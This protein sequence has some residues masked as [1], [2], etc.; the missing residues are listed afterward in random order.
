MELLGKLGI[1][2]KLLI[3][4]IINFGL[5]LWLFKKFLYRFIIRRI[6]KDE[7]ELDKARVLKDK[8][9]KERNEFQNQKTKELTEAHKKAENIIAEAEEI[10]QQ[11]K[12]QTCKEAKTEKEK[13]LRQIRERL[14][15]I[16][17]DEPK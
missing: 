1:D 3:A 15:N 6:E 13:V 17:D 5:L 10:A 12:E 9:E 2:I 4:Q 14:Q 11:I 16:Q 8:L 7:Q